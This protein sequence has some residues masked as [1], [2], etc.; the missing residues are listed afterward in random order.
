MKLSFVLALA[1]IAAMLSGWSIASAQVCVP[2]HA[3]DL[4][5]T[6]TPAIAAPG[7]KIT[8]TVT[9][10][11]AGC[12]YS[13]PSGCLV[14]SPRFTDCN[15]LDV[16]QTPIFCTAILKLIGPGSSTSY[17]W[18]Q[19]DSPGGVN[20]VGNGTY[21]F[22]LNLYDST[23]A[24]ASTCP[25]VQIGPPCQ[26][27]TP[28]GAGCAGSGG[29]VPELGWTGCS[30]VG[31][32]V[33][34]DIDKGLGGA[35]ML[36]FFGNAQ[37]NIPAGKCTLLVNPVLAMVSATLTGAGPGN[38]SLSIAG[39][40]PASAAN[41]TSDLQAWIVDPAVGIGAAGSNGLEVIVIP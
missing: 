22:P 28:Y 18:D 20:Q 15:G 5:I 32:I 11:S 16:I 23:G 26:T 13:Q 21:A 17:V 4:Q 25:T 1:T 12:M 10:V 33:S 37:G 38:G 35:T 24:P 36:L 3:A 14:Y 39:V 29:F 8:V 27:P 9:N 30:E 31:S 34:L 40:V 2:N 6:V 19:T 7:E 41:T